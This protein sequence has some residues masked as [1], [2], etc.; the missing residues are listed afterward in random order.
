MKYFFLVLGLV[1][2]FTAFSQT[3]PSKL[4]VG[5]YRTEGARNCGMKVTKNGS[6]LILSLTTNYTYSYTYCRAEGK[7]LVLREGGITTTD[8]RTI[9]GFYRLCDHATST[10]CYAVEVLGSDS[11]LFYE[12]NDEPSKYTLY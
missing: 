6:D 4:R 8:G 11:Y 10:W 5:T 2:S 1:I 7:T 12:N 9:E 3:S